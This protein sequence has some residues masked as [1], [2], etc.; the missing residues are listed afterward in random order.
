MKRWLTAVLCIAALTWVLT[1]C[2][3]NPGTSV[4]EQAFDKSKIDRE[5]TESNTRFAF[6]IFKMLNKEDQ[7]RNIFI[8]PISIS[9][10]LSMTY[11]G[12]GSTT[13]DAM[14]EALNYDGMDIGVINESYRHLIR[15]MRQLDRKV[16]LSIA[17]SLWIR[18][19]E[20]IKEDFLAVNRDVFDA[21][22]S[23]L[24]FSREDA[25]DRINEW[26]SKATKDKIEKML[27]PPIPGNVV[28]Y[29]INAIYFKGDWTVQF[30]KEKSFSSEFKAGNG[31]SGEVM[32][33]SRSGKVEYGQGEGFK[34]VRLPYGSGKIAMYCILPEE[35]VSVNDYI[36]S[37]DAGRWQ[38]VKESIAETEDVQLQLPRFKMEYGIKQLNDSLTSLGMGEA[39]GGS[40]DFSGIRDGIFISR[41]LHKA[42][43]DVNEEGSEAAGVTVVEKSESAAL[44][45]L[46]F[47]ANRPFVFVITDDDTGTILFLG[48]LYDVK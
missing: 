17:N 19:G 14:A 10:A 46:T 45:P 31:S 16:E 7:D 28:M 27:E 6:D 12:A 1:G 34:A 23:S 29:L 2:Y 18:Q 36:M 42:V 13:R 39:F 11:Q 26:I 21:A 33:M 22:I 47:I 5:F 38:A 35:G 40:A 41:V 9:T 20:K 4:K 3:S 24:D 37:L 43:I 15:Y 25:A 8:S 48:K 44:E 32:M 30:D